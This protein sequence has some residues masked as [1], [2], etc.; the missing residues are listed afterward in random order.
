MASDWL[1]YFWGEILSREAARTRQAFESLSDA[2]ERQAVLAHL[3]KMATEA[4]WA[5]P[6]RVSAQAALDA[7][8]DN[9]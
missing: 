3:Q 4:G 5:E 7:L 6:Q 1:E 8:R 2:E 9:L